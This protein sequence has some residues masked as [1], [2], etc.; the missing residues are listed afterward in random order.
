MSPG[1]LDEGTQ[2]PLVPRGPIKYLSSPTICMTRF[3]PKSCPAPNGRRRSGRAFRN[4][5]F[6]S[7]R[8]PPT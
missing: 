6:S 1:F 5:L 3:A 7:D 2:I 8:L 4:S